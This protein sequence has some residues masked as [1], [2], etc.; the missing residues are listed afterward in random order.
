MSATLTRQVVLKFCELCQW[1]YEVWVLRRAMFEDNPDIGKFRD[2]P[3]GYFLHN[4]GTISHEY[5]LTQIIKLHDPAIQQKSLNLTIEYIVEYGAWDKQTLAELRSLRDRLDVLAQKIRPARHK[6]MV[7]NDLATLPADEP[8]GA[9][10]AD[11][12]RTYFASLQELVNIVHER[13]IGGPHPFGGQ[14]R[15][16]AHLL[17]RALAADQARHS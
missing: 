1:A 16:D 8:L 17:F 14:S 13:V 10:P 15:G 11:A 4:F 3:H 5:A 9:F 7:H 2:G 12:D 6:I